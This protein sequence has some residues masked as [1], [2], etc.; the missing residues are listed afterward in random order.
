VCHCIVEAAAAL[1]GIESS[2]RRGST[3]VELPGQEGS[4]V[5]IKKGCN[6]QYVLGGGRMV[7]HGCDGVTASAM[8][9]IRKDIPCTSRSATAAYFA[10]CDYSTQTFSRL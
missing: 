6:N 1:S 2:G 5:R 9:A 8:D 10:G 3:G 7:R 4:S